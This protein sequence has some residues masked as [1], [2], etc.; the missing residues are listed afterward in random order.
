MCFL[1]NGMTCAA[2]QANVQRTVQNLTGVKDTNV[3]LLTGK[4]TVQADT[5][6]IDGSTIAAAVTKIGYDTTY[7]NALAKSETDLTITPMSRI[8]VAQQKAWDEAAAIKSRMIASICWLI[9]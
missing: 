8:N 6:L 5:N 4:M 9:R 2:C 7:E 1:V 3:N